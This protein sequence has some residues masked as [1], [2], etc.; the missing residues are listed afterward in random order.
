MRVANPDYRQKVEALFRRAA[1]LVDL[2]AEIDAIEPGLCITRLRVMPRMLQQDRFIHAAVQAA[3]ADHTAG[4]AAVTLVKPEETVLTVEYKINFLRPAVGQLLR[5]TSR[6][7]RPGA[8]LTVVE[9]EIHA[10]GAAGAEQLTAKAMVTLAIVR[11]AEAGGPDAVEHLTTQEGY[12]RWAELYDGED[13]P[14][15]ALEER[16]IDAL[17][18]DVSGLRIADLGCG[19]GRHVVRLAARGAIVT[20][21]D[22]SAGMLARAREK[23][24]GLSPPP[25]LIVHDL[26]ERLPL[27]EESF[28]CALS[29]LVLDHVPDLAGF[30]REMRRIVRPGGRVLVSVMHP[31]MGLRGVAARFRDP[32]S[33]R[34]VRPRSCD[35]QVGDYVSAAAQAGLTIALCREDAVDEALAERQPRARKYLG[36]PMLLMLSLKRG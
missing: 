29:A 4:G 9:S 22:F 36:W 19:T 11:L 35:H 3:L 18:P 17:L 8:H 23:C 28:D 14:L 32:A 30:F 2:G 13:N 5:A 31:A 25:V 15:V 26:A 1:F 16:E 27:D 20:G 21:L 34:E 33:G 10:I 7:L 24:A 12:D 6:V